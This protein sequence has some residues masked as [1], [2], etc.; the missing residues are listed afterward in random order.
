[1]L[2]RLT[3]EDYGLIPKAEISFERGATIFTGET[4]S[5]K[6]MV[7]GAIAFA[8]GERTSADVV[9]RGR[10]RAI[11]TLEFDADD[12]MRKQFITDG[13]DLEPD[14]DATVSR[15]L[16]A[17]SGKSTLRLNGRPTTAG[18]VREIASHVV[19]I[20]GQH[21]AQRLLAPAYHVELLDRFAG[22]A[23]LRARERVRSLHARLGETSHLLQSLNV[24]ERRAQEQFAFAKFALQ[25]IEA[26]AFEVDE[27][28]RLTQRRRVLDNAEKI[29]T[30]LRSAHDALAADED[31]AADAIGSAS[32]ALH[33]VSD[34]SNDFSELAR[35]ADALQSEINDLAL[36]ISRQLDAM[37]FDTAELEAINARLEILQTLKRKYG[38]S[39]RQVLDSA[40]EFRATIELFEN[41][42][43]R[44]IELEQNLKVTKNELDEEAAELSRLRRAA[45]DRLEKVVQAELKELALPSARLRV[46]FEPRSEIGPAG[47]EDMQFA[48]AAN[49]GEAERPLVRVASGGELSRVLLALMVILA[50]SRGR[51]ALIF[52]ELDAGVGGVTGTAVGTRLGRLAAHTQVIC[53]TH[54]AQIAS[55]AD[56]HYVLEK[57]ESRSGTTIGV[58]A[59]NDEQERIAELA[60]MLSGEGHDIALAHARSLIKQTNERRLAV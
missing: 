3:I 9:R 51:T 7:L 37:D 53:V 58:R 1:M 30:A 59:V 34:L 54:L 50:R 24:H 13:F 15:E 12:A 40:Q 23:T 27:D 25:E 16:S 38:G 36:A 2:R 33:H 49:K 6:T 10:P 60:R 8:L 11:V 55:W 4:G 22:D 31:S 46:Q 21:E 35:T 41:K 18:Y 47:S 32:T 57:N 29:V 42:D 52:D 48:F 39:L 45:A 17:E 20:A 14:E 56:R 5:G 28:E 44:R 19:D 43:E 26:A